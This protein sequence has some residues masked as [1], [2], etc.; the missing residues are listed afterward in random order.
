MDSITVIKNNSHQDSYVVKFS[1]ASIQNKLNEHDFQI[2]TLQYLQNSLLIIGP[3][4]NPHSFRSYYILSGKCLNPDTNEILETGDLLWINQSTEHAF[5]YMLEDTR[6]LL[7]AYQYDTFN[8]LRASASSLSEVLD[9]IQ[10]KDEY[11]GKHSSDVYILVLKFALRRGIK[12]NRLF[13]LIRAARYH[14]V[15]KVFIA[16]EILNKPGQLT[17]EEFDIMKTHVLKGKEMICEVINS[18]VFDIVVAH[19]ERLDGS[20]YPYGLKDDEITENGMIL[21]ICDTYDAMRSDRIYKKGKTKLEALDELKSIS[22][23]KFKKTLLDEFIKM[24]EEEDTL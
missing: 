13:N 15:G 12:G 1:D 19:H 8:T 20:G 22:G 3:S 18:D 23:I 21:S 17:S 4:S 11:T 9:T 16:D 10:L 14:D 24:I 5:L 7:H 2:N 6:I